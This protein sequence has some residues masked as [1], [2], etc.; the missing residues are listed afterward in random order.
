M[1]IKIVCW[2]DP[3]QIKQEL[4]TRLEYAKRAK[5]EIKKNWDRI[6]KT[7]YALD[8]Q[9]PYFATRLGSDANGQTT[10]TRSETPAPEVSMTYAY[11]NLRFIH[12]QMAANPP[13]AAPRPTNGDL[14]SK[15]SADL[16][17]K[18]IRYGQRQYGI[19]EIVE[20]GTLNALQYGTG[21]WKTVWNRELGDIL[22]VDEQTGEC[23]MEGDFQI[24]SI[25]PRKF[26]MDPDADHPTKIRWAFQEYAIPFE[27]AVYKFGKEKAEKL[28]DNMKQ[29]Q[30][31]S[32]IKKEDIIT[33]YE[34][35]EAGAPHNGFRGRYCICEPSGELI[36]EPGDNPHKFGKGG[37]IKKAYLPFHILTDIDV[38]NSLWGKS[39]L[40]YT[41]PLQELLNDIDTNMV[42][43]LAAHAVYRM[44]L[45]DGCELADDQPSNDNWDV[46]RTKG[47]RDPHF[48][49]PPSMPPDMSRTRQQIIE[50][51]DDL[52]GVNESMF[53]KQSRE[54]SG[55]LGQYNVNQ[56][57]MI[58]RR[59]L[60]KYA[61]VVETIMKHYLMLVTDKWTSKKTISVTGKEKAMETVS[62]VGA[63][64]EDGYELMVEYGTNLSLDPISRRE[65]IMQLQPMFKE[66]GISTMT[67]LKLMR[68][69]DLE[70]H[71]DVMEL[72]ENRQREYIEEIIAT[73]KYVAP[74][75]F[76]LHEGMLEY[77][78]KYRMSVDF[79]GLEKPVKDLILKHIAERI[80]MKE[81][82]KKLVAPA[83]EAAGMG[84]GMPADAM[85][86]VAPGMAPP[87]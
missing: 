71:F 58:R 39:F 44:I 33:V 31:V 60:N 55:F 42:D 68:L 11:K 85:A 62:L 18:V 26:F 51:I 17:D 78:I 30:G 63:D 37:K 40:D 79:K 87:V 23:I 50:A 84:A 43:A 41:I 29:K 4:H 74:E 45:P 20:V 15:H 16:C 59:L 54:T 32:E 34:Y 27:E 56:G 76:E 14:R 83:P 86:A 9:R 2:T 7:C 10:M 21:I 3:E 70:G 13:V 38:P 5:A 81:E 35:W 67:S 73:K 80:K 53:G 77:A 66:A 8:T 12:A 22:S 57:S 64:L 46:M 75:P 72:S 69:N 19:Q 61:S 25:D 1:A 48:I 28:K 49:T 47:N 24:T 82:E 52:S 65:E 36:G 6:D